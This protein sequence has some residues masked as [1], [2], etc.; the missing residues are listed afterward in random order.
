M[1]DKM[2]D[3]ITKKKANNPKNNGQPMTQPFRLL[4]GAVVPFL[5]MVVALLSWDSAAAKPA[6]NQPDKARRIAEGSL[7]REDGRSRYEQAVLISC[8]FHK[9]DGQRK[10]SSRPRV[11]RFKS[12]SKDVGRAGKDSTSLMV[13]T[14]PPS[15][16][17]SAFMQKDFDKSGKDSQQWLY[18]P[19]LNKMKRIVSAGSNEPKTGTLFGSEIAYEDLEKRHLADY[20]YSDNG[21]D[22][23]RGRP[24]HIITAYPKPHE[25]PQTSYSRSKMWI[26]QKT[27]IILKSKHYDKRGRLAK[28]FY[29]RGITR[30]KGVWL[31]Q[32]MIVVNHTKGRMSLLKTKKMAVNATIPEALV[33]QR[34]LEDAAYRKKQLKRLS[35]L[36]R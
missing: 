31:A 1:N 9:K 29:S 11:K 27:H 18:L 32:K 10:C 25:K 13:I 35:S 22:S 20:H 34:A 4:G 12:V 30:R 3:K 16:K 2:N 21:K 24:V 14:S 23:Y 8:D 17:G 5:F 15:E 33:S 19:A 7:N 26:D 28:T 36:A 6:L